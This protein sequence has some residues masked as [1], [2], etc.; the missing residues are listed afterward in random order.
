MRK[1]LGGR[2]G[3][4][5]APDVRP[6]VNENRIYIGNLDTRHVRENDVL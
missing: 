3:Y 2:D 1:G 6:E 5:L 4:V